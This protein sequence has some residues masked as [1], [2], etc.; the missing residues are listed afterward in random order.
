MI[1]YSEYKMGVLPL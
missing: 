1:L